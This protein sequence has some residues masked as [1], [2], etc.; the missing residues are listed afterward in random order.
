MGKGWGKPPS[1]AKR[2]EDYGSQKVNRVGEYQSHTVCPPAG[3]AV[4]GRKRVAGWDA[5]AGGL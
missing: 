5:P 2:G 1:V 4:R 3:T